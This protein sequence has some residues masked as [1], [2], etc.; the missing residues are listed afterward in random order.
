M[1][2]MDFVCYFRRSNKCSGQ[3]VL[4]VLKLGYLTNSVY[5]YI[6]WT[7]YI[8]KHNIKIKTSKQLKEASSN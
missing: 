2:Y 3:I 4:L 8:K 6:N 1:D 5:G 7:K